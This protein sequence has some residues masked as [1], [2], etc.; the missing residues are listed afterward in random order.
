MWQPT[1]GHY[2]TQRSG[3]LIGVLGTLAASDPASASTLAM[4]LE[5][6]R[7]RSEVIGQIA[8][9]WAE[10][11]PQEAIDWAMSLQAGDRRRG[12]S[13]V[14]AGWAEAAPAEAAAYVDEIPADQRGDYFIE[15]VANSWARQAP[16]V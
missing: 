2:E 4:E 11:S 14:L 15:N 16:A 8:E 6:G 5:P 10:R 1:P 7:A 3:A 13:E 9:A 12:V